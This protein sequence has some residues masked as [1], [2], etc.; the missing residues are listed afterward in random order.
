M[1]SKDLEQY[2]IG[3]VKKYTVDGN[4]EMTSLVDAFNKDLQLGTIVYQ[5]FLHLVSI[6]INYEK[7]YMEERKHDRVC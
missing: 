7:Q 4:C 3:K 1:T 6:L 2:F 5:E